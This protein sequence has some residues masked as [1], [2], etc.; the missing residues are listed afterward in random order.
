MTQI[1]VGF[2]DA[3][4]GRE[5]KTDGLWTHLGNMLLRTLTVTDKATLPAGTAQALTGSYRQNVTFN[6]PFNNNWYE[7]PASAS[8][9]M[10]GAPLV[11]LEACGTVGGNTAGM[12]IYVGFGLD[13]AVILPSQT[14]CMPPTANALVPF[15]IIGYWGQMTGE[16]RFAIFVY[17]NSGTGGLYSGSFTSLY[18]TEQRI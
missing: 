13:G 15:S 10:T 18:V 3:T 7:S 17:T 8:V 5:K 11:R 12:L 16:H 14:V 9:T 1:A 2:K 6:A 4:T